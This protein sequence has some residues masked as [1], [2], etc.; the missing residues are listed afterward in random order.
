MENKKHRMREKL[1]YQLFVTNVILFLFSYLF[2]IVA[3][4]FAFHFE[5][6]EFNFARALFHP[7]VTFSV[8]IFLGLNMALIFFF[9]FSKKFLKPIHELQKGMDQ[10]KNGNFNIRIENEFHNETQ[11]LINNFN[12]MVEELQ[13]SE[14]L[15]SDFI[16]NVSHEFKTP[17]SSIQGYATLLQ[18]ESLSKED[19][20]KYTKYII[21]ST[22]KLNVLIS[23]ILKISKI[24][25]QKI[26]IEQELFELDEQIREVVLSLEKE[27]TNKNIELDIDLD[28]VS[29]RTD[30]TLLSHVWSNIIGNA[31]K[32]SYDNS[33]IEIKLRNENDKIKVTIKDYGIGIEEE[34]VPYIFNKFYQGDTS[35]S[36]EG[37]GLGLALVKGIIDLINGKIEVKSEVNKGT[38]FIVTLNK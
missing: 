1:M 25:N 24:D 15:K 18:D 3:I 13:K 19:K 20:D 9:K 36:N 21:D 38:E 4:T 35:H 22:Q 10:V 30:K 33:K 31:I 17:L 5:E 11:D 7:T 2:V 12:L 8:I 16:S 37:N 26:V 32:Y 28:E 23:N 6:Y 29:I 34:K 14:T 27:W